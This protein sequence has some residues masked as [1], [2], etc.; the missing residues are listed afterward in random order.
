[1]KDKRVRVF[2]MLDEFYQAAADHFAGV[3]NQA[4]RSRGEASVA[5]SGGGTP[6]RLFQLLVKPPYPASIPWDA[7]HFYWGDERCVPPDHPESNFGQVKKILL[8]R[9]PVRQENVHPMRG[10]L[11][12]E[13]AVEDYRACLALHGSVD[14]PWPNLDYTLMGMGADG[15]TASL[16]PG[17][18]NP[19]E[20]VSPVIG[21][22]A[23]YLG[24]PAQRVTLTP[25]VFNTSQNVVFLVTGSDKAVVLAAVLNG[26]DDPIHLPAQRIQPA[27]GTLTWMVDASAA[28]FINGRR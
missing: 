12:L 1:M 10:E 20:E 6:Q 17:K 26:P 25:M 22:S 5:L 4:V 27:S 24:R 11:P 3:V 19:G 15:H 2:S 9:V 16:F 13:L 28:R 7:I 14:Q 21:V 23:D 8:D 18:V